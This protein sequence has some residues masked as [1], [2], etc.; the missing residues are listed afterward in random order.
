MNKYFYIVVTLCMLSPINAVRADMPPPGESE[1]FYEIGG[2][3]NIPTD[4]GGRDYVPF[5]ADIS[6]SLFGACGQFDPHYSVQQMINDF[7]DAFTQLGSYFTAMLGGLPG[8]IFCR[9][10][11]L[12]CQL[13]E[14][15]TARMEGFYK[16]GMDFC[17]EFQSSVVSDTDQTRG[18]LKSIQAEEWEDNAGGDENPE[19]T[20]REVSQVDG[21]SGVTWIGGVRAGGHG[22]PPL[23]VVAD[24]VKAGYNLQFGRNVLNSSVLNL[25]DADA[26]N[27]PIARYWRTPEEAAKWTT[28]VIGE[29]RPDIDESA[30]GISP[31]GTHSTDTRDSDGDQGEGGEDVVATQ[32]FLSADNNSPALGLLPKVHIE[33]QPI[34]DLIEEY[35]NTGIM[36]SNDDLQSISGT[37]STAVLTP[38]L[39]R[40]LR[41]SPMR[42]VLG[43]RLARE[44]AIANV[45]QMA[46][47][48]RRALIA[49]Y[50]EPNISSYEPARQQLAYR[51]ELMDKEIQM[52]L[53]E[54][55]VSR[56]LVSDTAL[57]LL[58]N[59]RSR[60]QSGP[61]ESSNSGPFMQ[62]GAVTQ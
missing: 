30:S 11:P 41:A 58:R 6:A 10:N 8:Y 44:I 43:A 17:Q 51:Q 24:T 47:A 62:G 39:L 18:W 28:E 32:E 16:T 48:A 37:S 52:L 55:D 13:Q 53:T 59:F 46:M 50:S 12:A 40:A 60:R 14:N 25:S 34:R 23:R 56:M 29:I 49:G 42:D 3:L 57:T 54:K 5:S 9:S 31:V 7:S 27:N 61:G 4:L 22:Q 19:E 33:E 15:I 45:A 20:S 26:A 38:E 35:I 21:S 36:P 2:G 1:L